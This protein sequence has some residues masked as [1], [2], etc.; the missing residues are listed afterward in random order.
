MDDKLALSGTVVRKTGD[1]YVNGTWTDAYAYYFDASYAFNNKH[2]LQFYALG[3]LRDMDKIY[4]NKTW[5]H[6][7]ENFSMN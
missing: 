6:M 5:L 4:T 1:G 3:A 2:R 7:T